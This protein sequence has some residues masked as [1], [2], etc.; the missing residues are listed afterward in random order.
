MT[1][2]ADYYVLQRVYEIGFCE[3]ATDTVVFI[4]EEPIS[5]ERE[6]SNAKAEEIVNYSLAEAVYYAQEKLGP[7]AVGII[8]S[9]GSPYVDYQAFNAIPYENEEEIVNE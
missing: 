7:D 9:N 4:D 2:P 5:F 3:Y 6:Y 8:D 1:K